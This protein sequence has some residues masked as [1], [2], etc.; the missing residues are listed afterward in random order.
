MLS[1]AVAIWIQIGNTKTAAT[2]LVANEVSNDAVTKTPARASGLRS[3]CP[4]CGGELHLKELRGRLRAIILT[5]G[6]QDAPSTW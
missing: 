2:L 1:T 4:E 5:T 6:G 3:T